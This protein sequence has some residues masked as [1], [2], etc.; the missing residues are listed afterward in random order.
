M[1]LKL[2]GTHFVKTAYRSLIKNRTNSFINIIGLSLGTLCFLYIILYVT[3]QYGYDQHHQNAKDIYRITSALQLPGENH[4]NSAVSPPTAPAMKRDFPEVKQF[5]RV[6]PSLGVSQYIIHFEEK[7]WSEKS[8]VFVDSTFFELFDYHF[9]YGDRSNALN[10]PYSI[11]LLKSIADKIFNTDDP[12]GKQIELEYAY[13]KGTYTVAGVIDESLGKSHIEANIFITMDGGGMGSY[14]KA[15]DS[16]AGNNFAYSYIKLSPQSNPAVVQAKLPEFL[17]KYGQEQLTQFGMEKQ[18][19]LQPVRSIHT[20]TG[21]ENELDKIAN[22]SFLKILLLIAALIQIIACINFMNLATARSADRAKEVGVRKAIGAGQSQLIAQFLWESILMAFM[23]VVIAVPLLWTTMPFLNELTQV[24]IPISF[25]KDYRLWLLLTS[26][27][28]ITGLLAGSYP[29]FYLSAFDSVKVLKGNFTNRVSVAG[30]RRSLVVFQFILAIV[31]ISAII[32]IYSQLRYIKNK[33]L[34][35]DQNQKVVFTFHTNETMNK[36]SKF[37][38]DLRGLAEVKSVSRAAYYLSQPI[39]SD[40]TFY[41]AG[42]SMANGQASR[43]MIS[44][45]FFAQANGIDI[46][47]GRD[48]RM[49]DSGKVLINQT[50]ATRLGINIAEAEGLSLF[51]KQGNGD[52]VKFEIVGILRDFNFNSLHEEIK[53]LMIMCNDLDPYLANIT[54]NTTSSDYKSLLSGIESIWN[55]NFPALPFEYAFLDAEVQKMYESEIALSNI[56]NI[57]TGMAIF[58]S[59]LGL[60]GL[61]SYSAENRRK[62]IG[63]RKVLGASTFRLTALL[64]Y[65]FISLVTIAFIIAAPLAWWAM[66][67]WLQSF[68]YRVMLTWQ[69]FGLAG[70]I[71]ILIAILTV[72]SQAVKAA[73]ANPIKSLRTE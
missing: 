71:A 9:I 27:I 22:P 25:L 28:I 62:E 2:P 53:P 72:S 23:G 57:F 4:I 10:K 14:A 18:L 69:M 34:G 16:W 56:I 13:G 51:S 68:N 38:S 40:Q 49:N 45:Q 12:I 15:N 47:S 55:E 50:L 35:F 19:H 42:G 17:K 61:A 67:K 48:F 58:I 8:V 70:L 20:T 44:D 3:D 63:I 21:F 5:A 30:I 46:I 59:C 43:L 1:F 41:K 11:V 39:L 64:S 54:V 32:V 65:D 7:A 73:I 26:L 33:D 24:D 60:F 52:P 6:I 37:A 36:G 66:N 31:L 29:A